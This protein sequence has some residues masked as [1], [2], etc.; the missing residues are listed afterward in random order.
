MVWQGTG[1]AVT[2]FHYTDQDAWSA[3]IDPV[4]PGLQTAGVIVPYSTNATS[5]FD[6][7]PL[8]WLSDSTDP[9]TTG[10]EPA[11]ATIRVTVRLS[12]G[13]VPWAVHKHE[14]GAG[15]GIS[16]PLEVAG[17]SDPATWYVVS[18]AI[19][20]TMWIE[21]VE[22]STGALLWQAEPRIS[23]S[24]LPAIRSARWIWMS[25]KPTSALATWRTQRRTSMPR[26]SSDK[27]AS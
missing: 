2:L 25:L 13:V 3:P 20:S 9:R 22:F 27:L 26:L 16:R 12:R 5:F 18:A 1:T 11:R 10:L 19:L 21:A 24:A 6:K 17:K 8:I 23:A 4:R 15:D 14:T 7:L